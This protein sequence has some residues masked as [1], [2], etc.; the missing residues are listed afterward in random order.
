MVFVMWLCMLVETA[1]KPFKLTDSK[2]LND[3]T[4]KRIKLH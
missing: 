1:E 2:D 3:I 4:L